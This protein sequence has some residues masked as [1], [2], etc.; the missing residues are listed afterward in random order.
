MPFSTTPV[1]VGAGDQIELRYPTPNTWN[2]S[3]TVQVQ[4]GTGVD[5]T[6][7]T[8]GTRAPDA[9][10]A[11]FSFID[12][13][14]ST[15][16]AASLPGDFTSTFQK[17]TTYYSNTITVSGVDLRIPIA[18]STSGSGPKGSYPNLANAGFSINNGP[19]IT[20][21]TQSV[22]V[23]GNTTSGSTTITNIASTTNLIVGRYIS[24]GSISGEI[25]SKTANTVTLTNKASATTTGDT[26]TQYYTVTN[27]DVI[28]LRIQTENWYTTNSNVTLTLSDNYWGAGNAVSDTWS[29]STRPQL[30][31][32]TSLNT[33]NGTGTFVDYVDIGPTEFGTYKTQNITITGI[34][35]DVVLR[36]TS[37]GNGQISKDGV[38]WSQSLTQLKL[39]DTLYTRLLV[40]ASY[41]TKTTGSFS[42]FAVGGETATINSVNYENN[43]AG[44]YGSGTFSVTQTIGSKQDDWQIWTEVDRYPNTVNFAPIYTNTDSLPLASVSSGGSGYTLNSIYPTVNTT[45]PTATGLTV[46][47]VQVSPTGAIEAVQIVERGTGPYSIDNI[48]TVTGGTVNAQVRLIQYRLVNV[49]TTSTLNNAE[50]GLT[51]YSDITIAGLGTEFTTGTYSDLEEPLVARTS[52]FTL[53]FTIPAG[54]S[55]QPVQIGCVVSQGDG[56]IRKN[57]AGAWVTSLTVQNGDVI[58]IK[59]TASTSFNTTKSSTIR[60]QGPPAGNPTNGNPTAGPN[61]PSFV[62]KEATI[63][64]KTR[65]ARTDPYPF[66]AAHVYQA[67]LGTPYIRTVPITGLDLQT[68][69]TIVS[70]SPGSNAQISIDGINYFTTI[71]NVPASTTIL[72]IS[73]TSSTSFN[74]TSTIVYKVGNTQD[75]FKITTRKNAYTY[76][77]FDPADVFYEYVIPQWASTIDF[78]LVG[79]GGGNGGD[80]YPNSFGG[81]G[82][83]GNVMTGSI[84]VDAIP[85]TDPINK[86][87]KIYSPRRGNNGTSFAKAS[88]GGTGGFGYATG[89]NG[90]ATASGEY[91]GSGGGGGGAAA[92]TLADGTLIALAGG[93][94]G[95]GGAGDDTVI[96]KVTQNGNYN[97]NGPNRIDSFV[98]FNLTGLA[99]T[100]ATLS[101]GGGGG[102]GGG[103]GTG[104]STNASLVD[105]FGGTLSV[106]D[107]DAN[108]GTGG[109]SYYKSAWVTISSTPDNLGAGT[110]Q[111]GISYIGYP[112]QDFTPDPFNFTPVSNATPNTLYES[113]I[114]QITGFNGFLPV[115]ISSNG[116]SQ[117]IRVCTGQGTGC[118]PWGSSATITN[119]QY[120]QVRMTTGDQFFTGYTLTI[121]AGTVTQYWNIDTGEP[122]D[123]LPNVFTI[124]D[125][126]NQPISTPV[127]SSIVQIT[128][129][130]SAATIT[131]SN[132]ALISICNGTT[133]DAFAASPRTISNGQ[134]FKLRI[135]TPATFQ[136]SI[137]SLVTV[138]SSS[139]VTW[140]VNT[141]V[142]PDNTPT[143]FA[144][145]TLSNQ[146]PNT[147]VTSNSA[148]IQSI[149]NTITFAVT[150]S[151]GQT[152]PL[153][154]IIVND[155]DTGL[156]STTVQLFD[157]V[158]LRYTTSNVVGD[159]KTWNIAAG[160]FTTTW[161]VT[162][163]GQFGTSPTPFLFPAV[164]ATAVNTN[165]NSNTVT[166]AGLGTTVG[167]YATNGAR[168]SKNGSAFN[169]YTSTTPLLISNGD[170]LRVQLLSSGI[171]GFSVSTDV[172]VGSY[173]TTFTV[174]SPAPASDP[175]L[176]QWYSALNM[177][178]VVGGNPIKFAAKFDGLPIGS[179]MPVFR[180]TTETDGWGN[181]DGKA[182]SRF[183]G[184]ILCDGSY[185][186]PNN[187]PALFA[188][189]GTIY[190]ANAGGD[191]RLPDMRN[192]KVMGTGSVDGNASSSPA[193]IPDYGPAK[194]A[195]NKSNLIPGSHGG[196]WYIDQIAVP[197][198]QSVP[199]VI[200][201]GTGLTATESNYFTIGTITTTGYTNVSGSVEFTTSGQI[202]AGISLLP[203][204]LYE[205]P[206]HTHLLV[207]GQPD[208]SIGGSGSKGI[209]FWNSNGG[210]ESQTNTGITIGTSPSQSTVTVLINLW[211][212]II[213]PPSGFVNLTSANTIPSAQ[214][215]DST[216][217][218]LQTA[219]EWGP[220]TGG[221]FNISGPGL[222]G[223]YI[224]ASRANVQYNQTNIGNVGS[225]NYDEI[226]SYINLTSEPFPTNASVVNS[227]DNY[228]HVAAVDIPTKNISIS[229]FNPVTKNDHTHYL[230]LSP[231]TNATTTFSYGNDNNHGTATSG[232]PTNTSINIVKTW[233]DLGLEVQ[234]G[235]F[236]L[237]ANKQLIPTPSLSPQSKVPLITPYVWVKWLI[238][239]Y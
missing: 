77:T 8:L 199:Q 170:T 233:A 99:G 94:G 213:S 23:T 100:S 206:S 50:I 127:D 162:N 58:T 159:S 12:N 24:S 68:T 123:N 105:E 222:T 115:S 81:R 42:V 225:A 63:T 204:K 64:I 86:A 198:A 91:S 181:L 176:G 70:E 66:R 54:I 22:V 21:S 182:N 152:G 36:A 102:A 117:Q 227:G 207:S 49:S 173:S 179:M 106:V 192:K 145:F 79:G 121:T 174:T 146:N 108:G 160:T 93:G 137:S 131:A 147:T 1:Y 57:G 110:N 201:P 155:V 59:K 10:P 153:P 144:F 142:Q 143:S 7:V 112:P 224:S 197:S 132:G 211:G 234:P 51:Y 228:K 89:G 193:L 156:S 6:G 111:D 230:S 219:S 138:G 183:P 67:N 104:G 232:T 17:N 217:V 46:K 53:P 28:R 118:G 238:K 60:L 34:D 231:I 107:L 126:S 129:I 109:G 186:S 191:F 163:A 165:T 221:C 180:D 178:Q 2:T 167:A 76:V 25:V 202:S 114:I 226:N 44:T 84:N 157:V 20:T 13:S 210:R 4:I 134:G 97:D 212:Y 75:T 14:G 223:T 71:S 41:T 88:A 83:N 90:G 47:V 33:G 80:D 164:I 172:F 52:S 103:Y 218:W 101:G 38:S 200:T 175:I 133:C 69:A 177:V 29:I 48:L 72:Y 26:L 215:A 19:Y 239:A 56:L 65:A 85:W 92:I 31:A 32:I 43:N 166:I 73:G 9:Q 216:T 214:D 195:A 140:T 196:L 45:N 158:K 203:T 78:V 139:A 15:N 98:G 189:L 35:N 120:I 168:L 194:S 62:D 184:W 171:A 161:T 169:T 18:V 16:S 141:G 122:P 220:S 154:T 185:V 209:V 96:Q 61:P 74:A 55:G 11:T 113:E 136:T 116:A 236:K 151:S 87:I 40:G 3:V 188:V 128:G 30:Q 125:L 135:T 190:G 187:F 27:G 82:G 130:N 124:P 229:S 39:G 148:T 205:A 5:P 37:T 237:N 208:P 95:G 149:D 150:N 119:N 235:N